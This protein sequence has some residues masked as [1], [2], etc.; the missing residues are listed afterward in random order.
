M[1]NL[2]KDIKIIVFL[3]ICFFI[4]VLSFSF[5]Y[6]IGIDDN[7]LEKESLKKDIALKEVKIELIQ[8]QINK[9]K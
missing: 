3:A 1:S 7:K 8:L 4:G 6:M 9:Q 2:K 5:G